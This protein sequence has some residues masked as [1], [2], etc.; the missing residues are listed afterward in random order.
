MNL[1]KTKDFKCFKK[2][3]W[4]KQIQFDIYKQWKIISS[5]IPVGI[6][7]IFGFGYNK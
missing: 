7:S 3:L 2:F 6:F 4:V 5:E 1:I